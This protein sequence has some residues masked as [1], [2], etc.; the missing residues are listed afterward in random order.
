MPRKRT[1]PQSRPNIKRIDTAED[2]AKQSHGWQVYISRQGKV[3]TRHFSDSKWRSKRAALKAAIADR[4]TMLAK[5]PPSYR[6]LGYQTKARSNTGHVGI[7]ESTRAM[8]KST[9]SHIIATVRAEEGT[10]MTKTIPFDSKQKKARAEAIA[11][12]VEWRAKHLRTRRRDWLKN[13]REKLAK[14]A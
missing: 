10:V 11:E 6:T 3:Y 4:D 2:A 5:L 7:S 9:R 14:S 1:N 12:A 8:A 13:Q